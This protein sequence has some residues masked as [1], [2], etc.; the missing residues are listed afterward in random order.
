VDGLLAANGDVSDL[1]RK[2]E[3]LMGDRQMLVSMS[4]SAVVNVQRYNIQH[5]AETWKHLF[6]EILAGDNK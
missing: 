5:I 2:M 6:E 3:M 4:R 1:A